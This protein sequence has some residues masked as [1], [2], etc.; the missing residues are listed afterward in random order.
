MEER[1]FEFS[2]SY[3]NKLAGHTIPEETISRILEAVGITGIQ[4]NQGILSLSIP[5]FRMDITCPAD[6]VEEIL[7]FYG[8]NNIPIPGKLNIPLVHAGKNQNDDLKDKIGNFLSSLGFSEVMNTSL[9]S[10]KFEGDSEAVK[11]ANPL[12][13]DLDV[14]RGSLLFNGLTN[15][16][17]NQNNK[18][19]DLKLFEFGRTYHK[20]QQGK[21]KE[22]E[23]LSMWISGTKTALSWNSKEQPAD[24][25]FLKKYIHAVIEKTNGMDNLKKTALENDAI[26]SYGYTINS[27]SGELVK[28]GK[29]REE[30][31]KKWD[32]K[33][34]VFFADFNWKTLLQQI[35]KGMEVKEIVKFPQVSRD[36][37][38]IIDKSVRFATL[39]EMAYKT[40]KEL[41]KEVSVFDVYEPAP[42]ESS[43]GKGIP[44]GKKSYALR[45]I[46]QSESKTLS[47]KEIEKVMDKLTKT[48][49]EQA[50]AVIR[51]S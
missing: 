29:I 41:L 51:S 11:I 13:A 10:S 19:S 12:S 30:I 7:R 8:Y 16:S 50:G 47:D 17:L 23:H 43:G 21:Y 24:F 40:E 22:K 49:T 37:A 38:L 27:N 35:P 6:I 39:M 26:F 36:L 5:T 32:I 42:T 14:L 33:G 15:I 3:L 28:A 4:K 34:E 31:L 45:F 1:K 48:F 20:S 18:H 44:E 46:L 25:Y 2:L 9:T